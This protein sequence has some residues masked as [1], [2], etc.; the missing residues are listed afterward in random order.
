[1]TVERGG[2]VIGSAK[3]TVQPGDPA[4]EVGWTVQAEAAGTCSWQDSTSSSRA[5]Y[6]AGCSDRRSPWLTC[7]LRGH[8]SSSCPTPCRTC[9]DMSISLSVQQSARPALT[10]RCSI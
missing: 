9:D 1:M 3:P 8:G 2:V 10:G 5:R 4:F 6:R 7:A